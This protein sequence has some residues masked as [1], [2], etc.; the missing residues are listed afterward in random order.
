MFRKDV[1]ASQL[2]LISGGVAVF[3]V[4]GVAANIKIIFAETFAS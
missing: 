4:P 2:T 1:T 3:S